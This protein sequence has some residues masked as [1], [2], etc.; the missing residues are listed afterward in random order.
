MSKSATR[1]HARPEY[2]LID[3]TGATAQNRMP[4][5]PAAI[6]DA[7]TVRSMLALPRALFALGR[8]R[9]VELLVEDARALVSIKP[10]L[11]ARWLSRGSCW[12]LD[13][14]GGRQKVGLQ[15]ILEAALGLTRSAFAWPVLRRRIA[16]E[17]AAL[18][19][20][21]DRPRFGAGPP[22]YLRCDISYG[23]RAGGSLGHIGG[24]IEG[25][26]RAGMTPVF[27]S[28]ERLPTVP[29]CVPLLEL[30]PG[31]P[32]WPRTEQTLLAF[33]AS[34][35]RQA[36]AQLQGRMP[37][38]IYQRHALG[39]YAGLALARHFRVPLVL[40][41]NG[42]ETWVAR[43]WGTGLQEPALLKRCED[44]VLRRADLIIT[45][46]DVLRRELLGRGV[47]AARIEVIPNGVNI[48]R[49]HPNRSVDALRRSLGL[50]AKTVVGFIGTF[51]PWHGVEV[52]VQAFA[53][54]LR[55]LPAMRDTLR[56]LLVGHGSRARA[57]TELIEHE[58][59]GANVVMTGT[60]AQSAGPD[61][62][63]LFDIAVAP[64]VPNPDG[65]PFFGSPTKLFEY[66]AAGKPIVA[67]GLGQVAEVLRD[68]ENGL[69]VA[70]GDIDALAQ[71]LIALV[72]DAD[73]RSRLGGAARRDA[74]RAHSDAARAEQLLQALQ[75]LAVSANFSA[76]A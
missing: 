72:R 47:P 74:E 42:P 15:F 60:V 27:A 59:I 29:P 12:L 76:C 44:V 65:T 10:L 55:R 31:P 35:V 63:A 64:T 1:A 2:A 75:R 51:G 5:A 8:F 45:V 17:L 24:V 52:L 14:R 49:F 3:L 7:E 38:F 16:A 26:S 66:M 25:L 6:M 4:S 22:L 11:A 70:G 69:L 46:S 23:L 34:V 9:R 73:L 53:R 58:G 18:D 54:V 37:R 28:V 48:E 62:I 21:V 43:H 30:S 32:R 33:N 36:K 39:A 71:A 67:S 68:G 19:T 20:N 41:Y 56:L 50:E 13:R 40:E 61:Y 57:V